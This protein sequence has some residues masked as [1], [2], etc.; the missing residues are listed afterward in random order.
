VLPQVWEARRRGVVFDAAN[1]VSHHSNIVAKAALAD[2]FLPDIISSDITLKGCFKKPVMF[3]LPYVMSKFLALGL[4][5]QQVIAAVTTVPAGLLGEER[6]L[7]SLSVGS[8]ADIFVL[9]VIRPKTPEMFGDIFGD[10]VCGNQLLKTEMTVRE[11]MIVY[12]QID[13]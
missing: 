9:R 1:G 10:F 11:G 8:C 3:S 4:T 13:F 5:I 6:E 7:G 2:G 12:R